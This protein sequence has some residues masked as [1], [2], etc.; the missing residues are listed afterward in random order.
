MAAEVEE[1]A[2]AEVEEEQQQEREEEEQVQQQKDDATMFGPKRLPRRIGDPCPQ[3]SHC[4][5][6]E[7]RKNEWDL[8]L[9]T[10]AR[11]GREHR[12]QQR[13]VQVAIGPR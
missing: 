3:S 12:P 5:H 6:E 10:L 2:V 11:R 4:L 13:S 9:S 8:C 1:E 7:A